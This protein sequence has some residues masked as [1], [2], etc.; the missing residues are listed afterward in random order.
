MAKKVFIQESFP[1]NN[2]SIM[3]VSAIL[4]R[5]IQE[6]V[7]DV[8]VFMASDILSVHPD[9]HDIIIELNMKPELGEEAF[10]IE[11]IE[12]GI[13]ISANDQRGLLYG[14]GKLL[15]TSN[16]ANCEFK[17][18][19][20]R[21]NSGPDK[22][23]RGVYLATHFN[24]YYHCA[25][26]EEIVEYIE[27]LALWGVNA[28][29]VWFDMHHY[30]SIEDPNANEMITRLRA[31]LKAVKGMGLMTALVGLGNEAYAESPVELRADWSQNPGYSRGLGSHYHVELC[32]NKPGAMDLMLKWK[33]EVFTEF[34]E[35]G[36]DFVL[37]APYDQGGCTC[38]ECYP[39]GGNG[40]LKISREASILTRKL[41]PDVKI[42]LSAWLFTYFV[43][44]FDP[45]E[46]KN[47]EK[48]LIEDS[49][50]VD[51]IMWDYN[52]TSITG[53]EFIY[54][55]YLKENGIPGGL[56]L[57]GF[58]EISMF[59]TLPY[60][61]WGANPQPDYI[62]R[63]WNKAGSAYEGGFPYSEGLYEDLNK[64]VCT[65][66]YWDETRNTD[67]IVK[68]YIEYEFSPEPDLAET[69][70]C[71]VKKMQSTYILHSR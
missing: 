56:P 10:A 21:G 62:Q 31:I 18:G 25:P 17:V 58:P 50:W 40:F 65:Q 41:L 71:A 12:G 47:L 68:E 39:W 19:S 14:A 42:I 53:T 9:E 28:I 61:G 8:T 43:P 38:L 24:N 66:L 23:I 27:D 5:K 45:V 13:R 26:I 49:S 64:I 1:T 59:A 37:F 11:D 2:L 36:I 22:E 30:T 57:L 34:L 48:L 35:I 46:W 15:R 69:I 6:R 63:L 3:K 52:T 44:D 29:A 4:K 70:F 67:D 32:P 33:E 7:D 51:Y 54:D 20:W 16:Y 55:Q 60:G